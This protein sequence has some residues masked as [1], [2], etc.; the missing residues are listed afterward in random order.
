M[1]HRNATTTTTPHAIT[2]TLDIARSAAFATT[3]HRGADP[4]TNQG[5]AP[6]DPAVSCD[7]AA[8]TT[9]SLAPPLILAGARSTTA[10]LFKLRGWFGGH[11]AT[12]LID[13][14][15]S[16]EF[17]DPDYAARCGLTLVPSDRTVK[18]ADGTITNALGQVT[19]SCALDA[20]RKPAVEFNSTFTATPLGGYDAILGVT[21]LAAHDV[22]I[23]WAHRSVI[24]HTPGHP[25]RA[26]RPLE[27]MDPSGEPSVSMLGT[28]SARSLRRAL[29]RGEVEEL[30]AVLGHPTHAAQPEAANDH[31]TAIK[32]LTLYKDVFPDKIPPGLPP[33]RGVEHAIELKPGASPPS[34]RPL[35]H[36]SYK[37]SATIQQYVQEGLEEGRLQVSQSP[38]GAM[39]LVVRKKDGTDRVVID[40]RGLNEITVKNRY[41]LPLMDE[42]FDRV[43]GARWFTKIDLRTGFHQIKIRPE[44]T[45][46]TAFRTRF[47]SFEYRVLPMGLCNAPGTFMELMNKTFEDM[48]DKSVLAFL[49]DILV[50]SKTEEEH[51][52]HVEQVLQRLRAQK[53]YAKLS[54]CELFRHRV[55]FLGHHI[56]ADGLAV[57]PDKVAAVK[58][59]PRPTNVQE[60]RSFNGFANFYRRFVRGYSL[61]ALPL[62]E[63]TRDGCTF[64]WGEPQQRAFGA[65]KQALT[66]AP[67]LLVPDPKLPFTL[68]CDA[69]D[70]AVGATLQQD[71]GSGLQPVAY[72][73]RKLTPAERNYD[74]REKEFLALVDAC[75]HWRHYLHSDQPFKLLSDHD[76]LKYHKS[77][78]HLTGRLARW[79]EKMAEFDYTIEHI[80]GVKNVVADALSRR[81]DLKPDPPDAE[82]PADNAATLAAVQRQR[83]GPQAAAGGEEQQRR[84]NREAAELSLPPAAG[85]PA[86]NEAGAIVM[87]SQ[88]CTATTKKGQHCR[89]R[90][91][92]G[93][94]CW[95]HLSSIA[96]LRI[97]PSSVPGA[98]AGLFASRDLPARTRIDYTGDR[99]VDVSI[100]DGGAYFLA[101][102]NTTVIDAARTNAGPGR[103]INDPRG[104]SAKA[105]ASFVIHTPPG[106]QRVACVRTLRPVQKG[107]EIL[108]K[109]GTDYWKFHLNRTAGKRPRRRRQR[110]AVRLSALQATTI[111]SGLT[112]ALLQ[113]AKKDKK[114]AE[115]LA[116]LPAGHQAIDGLIV[117]QDGKLLVPNDAALRTQLLAQCHDSTTGAHF[118]RD[119]TLSAMQARFAWD[120]M[121]T[122]VDQYVATCDACQR[123]KPTAQKTPGLLMPLP[124]P[125]RPCM[126]WTQDAV[127]GL[128]RTKRG[129]DAIQVYIERL[130]KFKHFAA[131][132]STD[133][134]SEL[135]TSFVHTVVRPHGV[136]EEI[137]SDRDPRFTA[138]YYA[139]LSKLLGITLRMSTARHPQTDGQSEREI[140]T[141]ITSLRAYCNDHQDDWDDHL[142]MLELGFNCAVQAS[143]QRS[144]YELLYGHLPRLPVD[145]ALA[146]F[147]PRNPAAIDRAERMQ[148]AAQFARN[149][150]LSAQERQAASAN[151]HRREAAFKVG[152]RVLLSTDGL[153]LRGFNSK[154]SSI[155]VGPF[156]VTAVVNANAYTLQLP[157]QL[158]A[159]HPTFNITKLKPYHATNEQRFPG[160]PLP[161]DRPPPEAQT[162]SNGDALFEVERIIAQRKRGKRLEYL[163]AWRGYPPEEYTW[164]PLSSLRNARDALATYH[165]NQRSAS[166]D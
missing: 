105:N 21:W 25:P 32:L 83:G 100:K 119:K 151:K 44:D 162:D 161:Y 75:S 54:K 157:P 122:A 62:T 12:L 36:Q 39:V 113:A 11:K 124:I 53:L 136:P 58:D 1:P 154:L 84:R 134:A 37:D 155:Y 165:D 114:Y 66:S 31:P 129:N 99:R 135:A 42:M 57:S 51:A 27:Y 121:A 116:A 14:G 61:L 69:C 108:V 67:V 18:L 78:P 163:V 76:S 5:T 17:I 130:Y 143:T 146:P 2:T 40:Y 127:T 148:Q 87:P 110:A 64:T 139:E 150:L 142:D 7:A 74:T 89:Q 128:P 82:Q 13:S 138:H 56:G 52:I 104:T 102:T 59:W 71:Q 144:P 93:Q 34:V 72:R 41:P 141:L 115:K 106:G 77:M 145:V 3:T 63:L 81:V 164:E 140:R 156:E 19:T 132:K 55:E 38:Y 153:Q 68:N 24:L 118:G 26:V 65:L 60:V 158:Q 112:D 109:Y 149:H 22:D 137:I 133:G 88:R 126:S 50:F 92:R 80:A 20:G 117:Q 96:G 131:G 23:G 160:R 101:L 46:K 6:T 30:Y 95:N 8:T 49:D 123:N 29:R 45:Y 15:A 103:W 159:L 147:A 85:L 166:R 97:K 86:P 35:H 152:D 125:D 91:A 107:E 111:S 16:S 4:N 28:I 79:V 90:T 48:L 47:G 33:E 94:Y 9:H 120:G 73:S 10:H 70:Y 43:N 98:G